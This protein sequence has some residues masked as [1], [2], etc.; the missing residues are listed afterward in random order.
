MNEQLMTYHVTDDG[1]VLI[2]PDLET[3]LDHIR[4]GML[5]TFHAGP[6]PRPLE[7]A[8]ES[9]WMNQAEYDALPE[10]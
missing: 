2:F 5:N 7:Y 8:I 3:A 9:K 1:D 4:Q 10:H 6:H